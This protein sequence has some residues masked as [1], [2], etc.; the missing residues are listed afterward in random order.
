MNLE[1]KTKRQKRTRILQTC[2]KGVTSFTSSHEK[3]V[4]LLRE[5][6]DWISDKGLI[7]QGHWEKNLIEKA[8]TFL[9]ENS[10]V[11]DI[12]ANLG[13]WSITLSHS[14]PLGRVYSF[15]PQTETYHQLG[16]NLFLNGCNN[17]RTF[18]VALGN[19]EQMKEQE[20]EGKYLLHDEFNL[21]NGAAHVPKHKERK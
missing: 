9:Q 19:E 20:K 6:W 2:D 11:I 5:N 18:Q 15:E 7:E 13:V 12:G 16:G 21:N 3:P 1:K 14:V 17:V 10:N 8:K 4:Y